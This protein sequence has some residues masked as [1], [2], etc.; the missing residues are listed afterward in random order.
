MLTVRVEN[1]AVPSAAVT[2]VAFESVPDPLEIVAVTVTPAVPRDTFGAEVKVVPL[3]TADGWVVI[4]INGSLIP[5]PLA[6]VKL[7]ES[8]EYS[9][10][11]FAFVALIFAL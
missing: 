7:E 4:E 5:P 3:V 1:V 2:A 6:G 8:E 9:P 10:S 11:P